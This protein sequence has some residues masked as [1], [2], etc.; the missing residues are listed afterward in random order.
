MGWKDFLDF[1]LNIWQIFVKTI[2]HC[3]TIKP[4]LA[5]ESQYQRIMNLP[6]KWRTKNGFI[7]RNEKEF[8]RKKESKSNFQFSI[9]ACTIDIDILKK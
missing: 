8:T 5:N 3:I 6:K 1:N 9:E 7:L 4:F 2:L